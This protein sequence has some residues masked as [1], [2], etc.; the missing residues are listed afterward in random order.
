MARS[1]TPL[2]WGLF[3]AGG[4]LAAFVLPA[5]VLVLLLAGYGKIPA[6]LD[7]ESIRA[8][9]GSWP[10]KAILFVIVA[11]SLWHAAHRMRDALHGLGLRADKAVAIGGYG[12]A[13]VGTGLAIYYLLQ[14]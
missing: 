10:G 9:A 11:L 14:I 12:G 13:A 2:V 8:F 3:A 4:T 7:Y 6:G 5:L 1:N